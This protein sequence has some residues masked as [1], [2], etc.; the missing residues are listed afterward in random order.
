MC[1]FP[2][3]PNML[4]IIKNFLC[5]KCP[6][7]SIVR[8]LVVM[9]VHVC[10]ELYFILTN[11]IIKKKKNILLFNCIL[12]FLLSL[13]FS[14]FLSSSRLCCI[15]FEINSNV[16]AFYVLSIF[17]AHTVCLVAWLW[18]VFIAHTFFFFFAF[19]ILVHKYSYLV[20]FI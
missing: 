7:P 8:D 16:F 14:Q 2:R 17:V 6:C 5:A 10:T 18:H 20:H 3:T 13:R 1:V 19:R 4:K 11:A 9:N 12:R 15:I